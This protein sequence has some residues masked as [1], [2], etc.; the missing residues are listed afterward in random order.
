MEQFLELEN[1]CQKASSNQGKENKATL[2][3][4]EYA[5]SRNNACHVQT[6]ETGMPYSRYE[7]RFFPYLIVSCACM[8]AQ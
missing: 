2:G 6:V 7:V 5:S 8:Q 4:Q 1:V 3:L